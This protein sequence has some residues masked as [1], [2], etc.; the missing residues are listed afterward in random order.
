MGPSHRIAVV[1][2]VCALALVGC[3]EESPPSPSVTTTTAS[4]SPASTTAAPTTA[5]P[6][7]SPSPAVPAGFSLDGRTSPTFPDLGGDL[8]G[9]GR[10]R[11]GHHEG[12]DR[13]VWEFPGTGRPTFKVHYVD[14]PLGDGSG[15][16]VSVEGDAYVEVLVTTVAIPADG[17]TRPAD[18]PASALAG[19]V[20]AQAHAIYGGFEG[21]GQ[22]FIGVTDERRPLRVTTLT[23]PTRLVVDVFNG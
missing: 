8:G 14:E 10:V 16:P 15:D 9:I 2:L 6:T 23:D 3:T 11:V 21:Y 20:I 4:P 12:Y 22:A 7:T 1:S 18:A 5:S 13:V 19:T 17:T